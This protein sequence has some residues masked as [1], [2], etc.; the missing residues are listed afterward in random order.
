MGYR[1]T[2]LAACLLL[3]MLPLLA[4]DTARG[5]EEMTAREMNKVSGQAGISL[6][7]DEATFYLYADSIKF[8]DKNTL[9][10]DGNEL[11]PDGYVR[12]GYKAL[13]VAEDFFEID[14][15]E[16]NQE[17]D[18]EF[19]DQTSDGEVTRTFEHP[20]NHTAMVFLD[21]SAGDEPFFNL[22]IQDISVYNHDSEAETA[23]GNLDAAGISLHE[24]RF[25]I[26]PP[27]DGGCGI[28]GIIGARAEIGLLEYTNPDKTADS[29]I[30]AAGAM[31][32]AGFSGAPEDPDAWEFDDGMFELGIPYY[33]HDD[34]EEEDTELDSYPFTLDITGVDDDSR[35]GDFQTFIAVR[36]PVRGS[37]RVK[38]ISSDNFDTGPIAI[39]GIRLYKNNI[40]FPGRGIGN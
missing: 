20:L 3:F 2:A 38:N 22:K 5:L 29:Q 40:E 14:I 8:Q 9:D 12:F 26:Y 24:S 27:T 36:A 13:L 25:N 34:P 16:F 18:L 11:S 19:T 35:S 17:D 31:L 1:L 6:A 7:T 33:Y 23:I 39:D 32:G 4:P 28:R 30:S 37:V 10:K 15:G 21:Q